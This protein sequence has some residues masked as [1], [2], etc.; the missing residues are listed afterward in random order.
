MFQSSPEPKPER[1]WRQHAEPEQPRCFNPRPS[2]SPSV[3]RFAPVRLV[4]IVVSILARAEARASHELGVKP[5]AIKK[6]SILARAEARA[7]LSRTLN[8]GRIG[9]FQSSPEPKPERHFA[10]YTVALTV[11]SFNPRP[12]R[13]P[14]VTRFK[15]RS[16][17]TAPRFNPR[18]SRSPSVTVATFYP[19]CRLSVSIL[20]RAEA[21]AS[22]AAELGQTAPPLVSILA[23]AE[24]RA[25]HF[26]STTGSQYPD[27]S[28]LARAEARASRHDGRGWT[29]RPCV[30]IL[31]RAKARASQWLLIKRLQCCKFQSSPEPKPERHSMITPPSRVDGLFQ[32]S[33]EPKPERHK[34]GVSSATARR[35]FQSSPEP[36]PERHIPAW[37]AKWSNFTF[38]SSPEPKPERHQIVPLDVCALVG[39]NPRP[40]QSPS[41][42]CC[43]PWAD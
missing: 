36:K 26:A 29:G 41:G 8:T 12:S 32:S 4:K 22:Q 43:Y 13:S 14:S 18:P 23:R 15:M 35:W 1:H 17:H 34:H 10:L 40:S 30:S 39:F 31:A 5:S 19:H 3:T 42:T 27:V 7:S 16:P 6:V 9:M 20:A 24:A 28:I 11:T 2:R 33:P 21:R 37:A 25:S 38:Q